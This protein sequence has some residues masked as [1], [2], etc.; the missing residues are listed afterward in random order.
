M[1]GRD[2][3]KSAPT[4]P[5]ARPDNK[6]HRSP[7]ESRSRIPAAL[8][9]GWRTAREAPLH[10]LALAAAL[11]IAAVFTGYNMFH[12]PQYEL[13]EGIYVGSAWAMFE[14]GQLYY[15]TYA[16]DHTLLGW[17]Q[18]GAFAELVGG[19]M[20]FGTSI[21]TG[22][23]LMLVS[24]VVSTLLIYLIVRHV[25]GRISAGLFAAVAFAVSPLGVTLHRQVW[26]DNLA[27]LWLLI[28][29][30][31]LVTSRGRMWR[32][33]LSALALSLAFWSKEVV[34]VL[35]PGML[36]LAYALAHPAHR[37]FAFGLWGAVVT[38]VASLFVVLALLK[39]E[40]LPPGV[41]WSSD[42]PHVSLIETYTRYASANGGSFLSPESDFRT[43]FGQWI[44]IDPFLMVGG[45]VAA[46]LGLLFFRRDRFFFGVSLLALLFVAFLATGGLVR[47]FYVIPLL[48]LLA[49]ALGL[50]AGH[51]ISAARKPT[52]ALLGAIS[53]REALRGKRL[54]YPAALAVFGLTVVWGVGAVP[55]NYVNFNGDRTTSQTQ[56]ARWVAENLPN[57]SVLLMDPYAWTDLRAEELV[58]DEPFRNA[59]SALTAL[60]D[61]AVREDVLQDPGRRGLPAIRGAEGRGAGLDRRLSRRDR[62]SEPSPGRRSPPII[63]PDTRVPLRR[64]AGGTPE[65][66]Q[67][68]P[69][70]RLRQPSPQ[71]H[72]AE[73]RGA[74]HKRRPGDRP[75]IGRPH[76]L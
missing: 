35:L 71:E 31:A 29:I 43:F 17:F 76:Y 50:L 75:Q 33:A 39:D 24:A 52:D 69:D 14:Q 37:K 73:L 28:S 46:A 48:A 58:G 59:H 54:A 21:N 51:A 45:L 56:A 68:A 22:R 30:Y 57:E 40:F 70:P 2:K 61:P 7:E 23:V 13:D 27:T 10:Y 25:T 34:V 32:L 26:I 42:E 36:Y 20:T 19:F 55:A 9:R 8:V 44:N 41:L 49:L 64:L 62:R 4:R 60:Q 16:Y 18:I 74:V 53:R 38:S 11:M 66:P 65:G 67:P 12:F 1:I 6:P 3:T 5:R 63:R 15:Y 47:F 72:L